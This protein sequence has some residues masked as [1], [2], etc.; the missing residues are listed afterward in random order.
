MCYNSYDL[1]IYWYVHVSDNMDQ[2]ENN[3][4]NYEFSWQN[5]NFF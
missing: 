2:S 3:T 1:D 4:H 5:S